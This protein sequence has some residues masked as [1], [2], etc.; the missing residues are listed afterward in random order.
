MAAAAAALQ[1]IN[2][3][4]TAACS[5]KENH[6]TKRIKNDWMCIFNMGVIHTY[7][8]LLRNLSRI[9]NRV[10]L[11]AV[12]AVLEAEGVVEADP[13][14]LFSNSAICAEFLS[15]PSSFFCVDMKRGKDADFTTVR[16]ADED[17]SNIDPFVFVVVWLLLVMVDHY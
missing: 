9:D 16:E 1:K 15:S 17:S 14:S 11:C 5:L 4:I 6:D 3:H 8:F 2:Q 12:V 10:V 13:S 7:Y